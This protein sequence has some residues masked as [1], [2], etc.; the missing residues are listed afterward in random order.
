MQTIDERIIE[1]K[2]VLAEMETLL[3]EQEK[4]GIVDAKLKSKIVDTE[5]LL[6]KLEK[7]K[8]EDKFTLPLDKKLKL[9]HQI[10]KGNAWGTLGI[11]G[12]EVGGIKDLPV[13]RLLDYVKQNTIDTSINIKNYWYVAARGG[14]IIV[15]SAEKNQ[16]QS[17]SELALK[18]F[19]GRELEI[20][21]REIKLLNY[22]L[23]SLYT[24]YNKVDNE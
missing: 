13:Q 1:T 10:I 7:R 23:Y 21:E 16:N 8:E 5:W 6:F 18:L 17:L 2:S 22:S 4:N 14:E 12:Y 9:A 24:M 15:M 20:I 19:K 11:M 3:Q